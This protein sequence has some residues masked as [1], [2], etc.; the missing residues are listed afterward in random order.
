MRKIEL[1]LLLLI[2]V[3]I[4]GCSDEKKPFFI[5]NIKVIN[6]E[7]QRSISGVHLNV[8]S[9]GVDDVAVLGPYL[10]LGIYGSPYLTKIYNLKTLDFIGN[11]LFKGH[12]PNDFG[13]IDIIKT[14]YPYFWIQDRLYENVQLINVEDIIKDKHAAAKKVLHYG[15]IVEPF[16]AFYINDTCLLIKSFDVNKGLYYVY[17]NPKNG[18]LSRKVV[19]YSY[20][21]TSDILY[22]KMIP[23][24]DCMK[25]DGSK[26]VS[27]S[28]ILDQID[29]LDM[30]NPEKSISVTTTNHQYSYEYIKNTHSDE[31]KTFYFSY[32]YCSEELIFALYENKDTKNLN[33]IELHVIDWEGNPIYKL[34]LDQRIDIFS[35][36]S[37]FMYGIS[38]IEEKLYRYDIRDIIL[39]KSKLK[40]N[41]D[42]S[43]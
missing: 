27:I 24:A 1:F 22:N 34:F 42:S 36:D 23:L 6:F 13:Y 15:N 8:D 17:Y 35:M 43:L 29:I 5:G 38:K 10:I 41:S 32:P 18:N 4:C 9:I 25:P 39:P 11:F 33:N 3:A 12:G 16:N 14:A 37:G 21:V 19:M 26:I 20:P 2:A 28:G 7:K 30:H 31:M 40:P